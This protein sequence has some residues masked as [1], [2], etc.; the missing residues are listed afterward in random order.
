MRRRRFLALLALAAAVPTEAARADDTAKGP[1]PGKYRIMSYGAT[2]RPPLH[3]GSFVLGSGT[4]KAYLPGDK[5]QGE[6]A[7]AY[8]ATT[9]TVTWK[10]GPY[11]GTWGGAFTVERDGKTHKIRLK[12]TTIATN[13]ID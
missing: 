10:T 12:P 8:D 5:P 4:Y 13:N 1:R 9:Q 2:N 11:A 3:L 7:Y 6:G